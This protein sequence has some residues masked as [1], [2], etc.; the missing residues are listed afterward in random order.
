M[1][2]KE[3]EEKTQGGE[4][5]KGRVRQDEEEETN[6]KREENGYIKKVVRESA[7]LRHLKFLRLVNPTQI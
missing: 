5:R 7:G 2:I 4:N 1:N 3:E 6:S